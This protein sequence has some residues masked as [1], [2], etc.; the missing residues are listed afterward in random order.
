MSDY[1]TTIIAVEEAWTLAHALFC[2]RVNSFVE[3]RGSQANPLPVGRVPAG[4]TLDAALGGLKVA[5]HRLRNY[6]NVPDSSPWLVVGA[7]PVN[8]GAEVDYQLQQCADAADNASVVLTTASLVDIQGAEKIR[9]WLTSEKTKA[10][11]DTLSLRQWNALQAMDELKAF[12]P[13]CRAT[14]KEIADKA[15]RA[16]TDAFKHPLRDLVEKG[17]I[18]STGS[19]GGAGGGYWLTAEGLAVLSQCRS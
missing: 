18:A 4:L 12:S 10:L 19:R 6:I 14:A 9:A 7:V 13:D 15:E 8:S 16:S 11:S 1:L 17:L 5:I 2:Q 3:E